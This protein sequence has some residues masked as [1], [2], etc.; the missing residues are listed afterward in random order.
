MV[1]VAVHKTFRCGQANLLLPRWYIACAYIIDSGL[2]RDL[3]LK[4][5]PSIVMSTADNQPCLTALFAMC[6]F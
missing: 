6:F 4:R 1:L 5:R 2:F 3:L